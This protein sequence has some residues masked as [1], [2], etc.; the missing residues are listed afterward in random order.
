MVVMGG[1]WSLYVLTEVMI[2]I[3]VVRR[4][5]SIAFRTLARS[6]GVVD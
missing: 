1:M 4:V 2:F 3:M 5:D 6:A